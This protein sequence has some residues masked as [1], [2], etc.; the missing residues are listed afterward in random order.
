M[1]KLIDL[2]KGSQNRQLFISTHSDL[3][4]TRI[5]LRKCILLNSSGMSSTNLSK[6]D[7][8]TARFFMK[9]PDNNMLQFVLSQ[10]IILVEGDAEFILMEAMYKQITHKDFARSGIG[11]ISVDGKCFKRYLEIGKLL[12]IKVAV[13]TDNDKNYEDNIKGNYK[14][15]EN[16]KVFS[17]ADN[18]R[19][20]FEVCIYEDNKTILNGEFNHLRKNTPLQYMLANKAESAY[21]ILTKYADKLKVPQYIQYAI[22]W[23]DA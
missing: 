23:I 9:A 10:K 15:T 5:N 7:D 18:K 16:I 1:L 13:I 19:Y 17:D 2:I 20:T 4:S 6:I 3:I 14:E 22:Q 8:E 12:G 21:R 11:V